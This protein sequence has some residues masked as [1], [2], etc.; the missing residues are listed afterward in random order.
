MNNIS[1]FTKEGSVYELLC[2]LYDQVAA[3]KLASFKELKAYAAPVPKGQRLAVILK[4][5]FEL[6]R[7]LYWGFFSP[8]SPE[9]YP[10]LWSRM[11]LP[12]K[13]YP[14]A[15]DLRRYATIPETFLCM[16]DIHGYTRYCRDHRHNPS[17]L[18]LLDRMLQEDVPRLVAASGVLSRRTRGDELL[19]LGASACDVL[20]ATLKVISYLSSGRR[21]GPS[22]A[23]D[24]RGAPTLPEFQVSAG[25]A[26]GQMY[27]SLVVTRDGDLSGDIVNASARLQARANKISPQ[28]NKILVTSHVY[29]HLKGAGAAL[30]AVEGINDIDFFNAGPVEFKG[31]AL[32]VYDVVFLKAEARRLDYRNAMESL[33]EALDKDLW[34]SAVF[35]QS[36]ALASRLADCIGGDPAED[37][38]R[39]SIKALIKA[40][41]EAFTATRYEYACAA[42]RRIVVDLGLRDSSDALALDY[43]RQIAAAYDRIVAGFTETIDAELDQHLDAALSPKE[44]E[45]Y[46]LLRRHHGLYEELRDR[47][48]LK[49]RGRKALWFKE[50]DKALDY[51]EIR[52]HSGK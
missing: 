49:I 13:D 25:I 24:A 34:K 52:I 1:E 12:D 4:K 46:R 50:T 42:L 28:R 2:H 17:M 18:D 45:Q 37:E 33:Y 38:R 41:S 31:V 44:I 16:M 21:Q 6:Q 3:G 48:R 30:R 10:A 14:F 36:M 22:A 7:R 39:G 32:T 5:C 43:L 27:S 8:L 11:V 15:G 35:E 20:D 40:A 47:A 23:S 29:Q 9:A 26:G 19:L 51:L